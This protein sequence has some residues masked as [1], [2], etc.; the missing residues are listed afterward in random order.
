M[1]KLEIVGYEQD[2]NCEHC[3]RGLKHCIRLSD[4]RIV[5]ATCFDKKIT[6]PKIYQGKK[7]RVGSAHIIKLAKVAQF[8]PAHKWSLYGVGHLSLSFEAA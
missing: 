8:V 3:G 4:G 2:G 5:G 1:S 7:Y 6:Q